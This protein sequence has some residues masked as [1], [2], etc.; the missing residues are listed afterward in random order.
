MGIYAKSTRNRKFFKRRSKKGARRARRGLATKRDL[1]LLSR[2]ITATREVKHAF[3]TQTFS[4]G[5]YNAANEGING[6]YCTRNLGI[7]GG[8]GEIGIPLGTA[9]NQRIGSSI[10]IKKVMLR[11]NFTVNGV[12]QNSNPVPKPQLVKVMF[13]YSKPQLGEDRQKLPTQALALYMY[14]GSANNPAGDTRDLNINKINTK[15][16]TIVKKSRT[17]KIGNA[18]Y[19]Q[20]QVAQQDFQNNTFVMYKNYTADL[21]KF[22]HKTQN[23]YSNDSGSSNRTLSMYITTCDATGESSTSF[24]LS[25]NYELCVS[26]TDS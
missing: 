24:P 22:F 18:G 4:F 17:M 8:V 26:Y 20:G 23:F 6:T 15:L 9:Q 19:L 1:Y 12:V 13:G 16:Y 11:M 25:C 21:T 14:G 10:R 7:T 2:Q 3:T 5:S